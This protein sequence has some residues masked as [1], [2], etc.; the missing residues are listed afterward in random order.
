MWGGMEIAVPYLILAAL[1][2]LA[3]CRIWDRMS[4][5]NHM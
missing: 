4:H 2:M 3:L 1:A 5:R